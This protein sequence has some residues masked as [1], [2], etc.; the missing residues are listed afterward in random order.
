MR[1]ATLIPTLAAAALLLMV[2]A[3]AK[4]GENLS[5]QEQIDA[6]AKK[7]K[8]LQNERIATL[9]A[10]VET[11]KVLFQNGRIDFEEVIDA[12]LQL[13]DAELEV[14]E[15]ASDRVA[16]NKKMVDVLKQYEGLAESNVERARASRVVA[17]KIKA[18]RLEAEI[19][20][21][22]AKAAEANAKP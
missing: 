13:L 9:K 5:R 21:E 2:S 1:I 22:Q 19:H 12:Q 7:V 15:K 18:R 8:E 6:S 20:W 10:V 4:G 3:G 17:L 14:A 11:A 16:L